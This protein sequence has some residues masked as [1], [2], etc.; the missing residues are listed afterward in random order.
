MVSFDGNHP[1]ISPSVAGSRDLTV[2]IVGR[3]GQGVGLAG[4]VIAE[5]AALEG[6]WLW[7]REVFKEVGEVVGTGSV[8]RLASHQPPSPVPGLRIDLLLALDVS[9]GHRCRRLLKPTG[10]VIFV[11][12]PVRSAW[13]GRL[14]HAPLPPGEALW[15]DA[16]RQTS[17][18][19]GPLPWPIPAPDKSRLTAPV[20]AIGLLLGQASRGLPLSADSWHAALETQLP[21]VRVARCR[22]MFAAGRLRARRWA[23]GL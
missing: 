9:F 13:P 23:D 20:E 1:Y 12:G 6:Y 10:A 16:D 14:D 5:A 8:L 2:L 22:E 17:A 21:S 7:R 11:P 4:D 15:R 3:L 18:A 19:D